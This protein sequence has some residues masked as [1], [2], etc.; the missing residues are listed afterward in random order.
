MMFTTSVAKDQI[1]QAGYLYVPRCIQSVDLIANADTFVNAAID[2]FEQNEET[3]DGKTTTVLYQRCGTLNDDESIPRTEK[4]A[5]DVTDYRPT[6][7]P[8]HR[9]AKP[10]QRPEPP[11]MPPMPGASL[12][13]KAV[14]A[15]GRDKDLVT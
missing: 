2:N 9:Y 5:L 13:D 8:L 10:Q 1:S 14:F 7:E 12:L 4:E 6:E 11:P 15:K 3:F